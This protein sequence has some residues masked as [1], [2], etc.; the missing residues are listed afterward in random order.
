[1]NLLIK[2]ND[3][4]I[5]KDKPNSVFYL[6]VK[7]KTQRLKQAKNKGVGKGFLLYMGIIREQGL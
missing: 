3:F 7:L 5:S 4:K 1:M 2:E 6:I